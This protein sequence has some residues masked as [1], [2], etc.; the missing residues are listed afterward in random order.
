MDIKL[1]GD[2]DGIDAAQVIVDRY[3]IP[4]IFLTS[5]ADDKN[6]QRAKTLG[7]YGYIL[8]PFEKEELNKAIEI[9]IYRHGMHLLV[10]DNAERFKKLSAA[11]FEGIL[12]TD[13]NIIIDVNKRFA[14]MFGYEIED[15]IGK[16]ARILFCPPVMGE[17]SFF[18]STESDVFC[19]AL[20]CKK[21][22][23]NF[24]VEVRS[25]YDCFN[26]TRH[27]VTAVNDITY[28]KEAL[29]EVAAA[30]SMTHSILERSPFGVMVIDEQ[31]YVEFINPAMVQLSGEKKE[32]LLKINI[33]THK[34]Y[35]RI[36]LSDKI[37][38]CLQGDSFFIGPVEYTNIKSDK[39]TIKNFTGIPFCEEKQIRLLFTSRI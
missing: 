29:N 39:I 18:S 17:K 32:E 14:S 15:L 26:G 13:K 33:L 31:G 9:A 22:S 7:S 30:H 28:R 3:D 6:F 19:E 21:D 5:Y 38:T 36:G 23:S 25:R 37:K 12:M 10:K 11:S 35:E 34:S 24:Y 8:K 4:V 1:T 20:G 27:R 2:S 16:D